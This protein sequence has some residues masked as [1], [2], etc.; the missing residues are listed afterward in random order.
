MD[1]QYPDIWISGVLHDPPGVLPRRPVD[2]TFFLLFFA[3]NIFKTYLDIGAPTPPPGSRG[4]PR[5][6]ERVQQNMAPDF[7]TY[8]Q[9]A[10]FSPL[11]LFNISWHRLTVGSILIC[12]NQVN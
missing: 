10:K 7:L 8:Y 6:L 1:I 5:C 9:A 2:D 3:K 12:E 4:V 11:F